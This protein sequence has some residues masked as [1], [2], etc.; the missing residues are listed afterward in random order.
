MENQ[1]NGTVALIGLG[2]MGAFF[3]PRFAKQL[4]KR[5][6]VIADG[7]RKERLE[8]QGVTIN[9][10][11]WKFPVETPDGEPSPC[12]L[13]VI[14]VKDYTLPDAIL[15][16]RRFVGEHT[17][18]LCVM[19]GVTS[20]ES[21]AA[22]YGR[23]HVL[24]S[25]MRVSIAMEDGSAVFD[26]KKGCVCFGEAENDPEHLSDRVRLVRALFE[27]CGVPYRIPRDMKHAL[28]FKFLCNVGDNMTCALLGVPFGVFT[29]SR[30]ANEIRVAAMHEV[31]RLAE[32]KGIRI[33]D[34]EIRALDK[35]YASFP[36]MNRPSTL[37]DLERGRQTEVSMFAGYVVAESEK[38]GL[39][40]P[41]CW[42]FD[43]GIRVLEEKNEGAFRP[44]K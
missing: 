39:H 23:E 13:I 42:M 26:P 36:F 38:Y 29:K 32:K 1:M 35:T 9:G 17:L 5:F 6:F 41:V 40:A 22:A 31:Q 12:D 7:E 8:R 11:N 20:E 24:Y 25:F 33:T 14:A 3:A 34:E 28:W 18:I 21:V 10:T 37:Q 30:E 2:A 19:N 27:Q 43:K 44:E 16:I 4:G 15:D